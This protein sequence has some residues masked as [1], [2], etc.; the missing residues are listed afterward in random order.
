MPAAA[1]RP[2]TLDLV[3]D[4]VADRTRRSILDRLQRGPQT[5]TA[6]AEPYNMSLNGVSKHLK[7]L[8]RA[9]LIRR[10]IRG[11]EHYCR[12]DA[13]RLRT[14]MDWMEHYRE[15]WTERLDA[16]EQHLIEKRKGAKK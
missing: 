11:R 6:L 9:G 4:A 14:A 13:R 8:Q 15:F 3:F 5:V 1:T 16:L 10:E 2:D 12:L 7:K